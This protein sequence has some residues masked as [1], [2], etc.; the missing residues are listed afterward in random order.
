[1]KE[2]QKAIMWKCCTRTDSLGNRKDNSHGS[3]VMAEPVTNLINE[4]Q[5]SEVNWSY[6]FLHHRNKNEGACD[7]GILLFFP[8]GRCFSSQTRV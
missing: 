7:G 6:G 3:L 2:P 8:Y 4:T 1:M 5:T